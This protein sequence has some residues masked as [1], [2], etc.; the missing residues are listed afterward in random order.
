MQP[1]YP[2]QIG[3]ALRTHWKTQQ[4][5]HNSSCEAA[6]LLQV[7][8]PQ[9]DGRW[10]GTGQ[11][12]ERKEEEKVIAN[13]TAAAESSFCLQGRGRNKNKFGMHFLQKLK[14]RGALPAGP[15]PI[16]QLLL[17]EDSS[18]GRSIHGVYHLRAFCPWNLP[19]WNAQGRVQ[20]LVPLHSLQIDNKHSSALLLL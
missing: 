19:H 3:S 5:D 10:K 6:G 9:R 2:Q 1:L 17:Q 18:N 12:S 16:Q 4:K 8:L 13:Q 7:D 20:N 11:K 15:L 14:R